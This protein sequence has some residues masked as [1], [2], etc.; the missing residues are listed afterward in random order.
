MCNAA[1]WLVVVE[2]GHGDIVT[3][4]NLPQEEGQ[5]GNGVR[6]W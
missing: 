3:V 2:I 1:T 4:E 6:E 5:L